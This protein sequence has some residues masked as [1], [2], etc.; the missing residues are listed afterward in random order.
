M[1]LLKSHS[2]FTLMEL[3]LVIGMLGIMAALVIS[4][5]NPTKQLGEARDTQRRS[6][7]NQLKKS[8]LQY[9]IDGNDEGTLPLTIG[10]AIAI[11]SSAN[12]GAS[13]NGTGTG[14]DASYLVPNYL[15]DIPSDPDIVNSGVSG[16]HIY[17]D[18]GTF[19]QVCSPSLDEA[20]AGG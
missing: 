18:N 3:L 17:K 10:T 12:T 2:G 1:S 14:Y 16:Y 5:I 9:V 19:L 6:D 8:V 4:A 15:T 20:C 7:I 11:C 13:C